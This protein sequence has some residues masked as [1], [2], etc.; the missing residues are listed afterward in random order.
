MKADLL[1]AGPLLNPARH[2]IAGLDALLQEI[3]REKGRRIE[4]GEVFAGDVLEI[5]AATVT[6]L[7]EDPVLPTGDGAVLKA[8]VADSSGHFRAK[9]DAGEE[10]ADQRAVLD[11]DVFRRS[12]QAQC[13]QAPAGLQGNRIVARIDVAML[14]AHVLARIHVDAV[15]VGVGGADQEIPGSEVSAEEQMDGPEALVLGRETVQ[16]DVGRVCQFDQSRAAWVAQS[17]QAD[18]RAEDRARTEDGE[19]AGLLGRDERP[20]AVRKFAFPAHAHQGIIL[21]VGA[22]HEA[23]P[24]FK[25]QC[26]LRPENDAASQVD[27]RWH[28]D[29]AASRA[30]T[31]IERFLERGRILG[32]S[33]ARCAEIADVEHGEGCRG[34]RRGRAIGRARQQTTKKESETKK[35]PT[36]HRM[37]E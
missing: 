35:T 31:G 28:D 36:I 20:V 14:D 33:V 15:A 26:G 17:A 27:S 5:A 9:T 37:Q 32:M 19:V 23:G 8:H 10:A 12:V 34:R 7:D 29:G 18:G 1:H 6:A 11:H 2:G 3:D 22:A 30:R 24:R 4:D 13:G 25:F 21:D 16:H